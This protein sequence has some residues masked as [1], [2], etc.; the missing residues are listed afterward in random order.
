[1]RWTIYDEAVQN[2]LALFVVITYLV[3]TF[4]LYEVPVELKIFTGAVLVGYGFKV[5]KTKINGE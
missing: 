4:K 1:M 2:I 5:F 3:M